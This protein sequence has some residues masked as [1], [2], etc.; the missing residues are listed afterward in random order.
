M[1]VHN[2]PTAF[3]DDDVESIDLLHYWRIVRQ[4]WIGILGLGLVVSMLTALSVMRTTPIYRA[5]ATILIESQRPNTVSIQEVYDSQ[6]RSFRYFTT[7]F[8]IIKNRDIA[9]LAANKLDLWNH[10]T[11]MPRKAT[12]DTEGEGESE[13]EEGFNWNPRAWISDLITTPAS[14]Q[15]AR[16]REQAMPVD[17]EE[18]HRNAVI[19]KL[20]GGLSVEQVEYTQLGKITF[21][22]TDRKLA[23][24][25]ANTV[26]EVYIQAQMDSNL[27]STQEAGQWLSSRLGDLKANLQASQLAL[28]EFRDKEQILDVSGGQDLGVQ[29]LNDLNSRLGAAREERI[30]KE[31]ILEELARAN[32]YSIAELMSMPTVL[33]HP[34]VQSL[35]GSLTEAQQDVANLSRRYGP[36]HPRMITAITRKDSIQAELNEQLAQVATGPLIVFH[37][38]I[39]R[40]IM[41]IIDGKG[42][43]LIR[44][45]CQ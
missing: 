10:P 35:A 37:I 29:E 12:V 25:I 8:E 11:F 39:E 1:Q 30:E 40:I 14:R 13:G 38:K 17:A 24:Q 15:E 19:N 16:E 42:F 33:Q 41:A 27:K 28:Q 23:A 18:L 7:Q 20:L 36:E 22:S 34:L 45:K 26:A 31:I 6:F 32:D 4:S 43:R 44:M 9:E 21:T 3:Q 5:T 2:L